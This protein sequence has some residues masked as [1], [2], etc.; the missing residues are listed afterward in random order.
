MLRFAGFAT[1]LVVAVMALGSAAFAASQTGSCTTTRTDYKTSTSYL[2]IGENSRILPETTLT[3][4]SGQAGCLLV[5]FSA[6]VVVEAGPTVTGIWVAAVRANAL[7]CEPGQVVFVRA[8][9]GIIGSTAAM[10]FICRNVPAGTHRIDIQARRFGNG[11]ASISKRTIT[12]GY[13][14]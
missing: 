9:D 13:T 4:T 12:V 6:D 10:T 1:A 5:T 3:V 8:N 14:R 2:V 7:I 11:E